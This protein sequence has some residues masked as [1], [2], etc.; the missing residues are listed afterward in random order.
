L[1]PNFKSEMKR[2]VHF[3]CKNLCYKKKT[4][5]ETWSKK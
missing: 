3:K 5:N 2:R 1:R 4:K